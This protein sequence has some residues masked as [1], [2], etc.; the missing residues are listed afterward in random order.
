MFVSEVHAKW[1]NYA[2]QTRSV[3]MDA[4]QHS[5]ADTMRGRLS[6]ALHYSDT[7]NGEKALVAYALENGES[8]T[9]YKLFNYTDERPLLTVKYW[10]VDGNVTSRRVD[11]REVDPSAC[12][13]T[14]L[15]AFTAY[16]A[17]RGGSKSGI[18]SV[19]PGEN[20]EKPCQDD[21]VMLE[22]LDYLSIT[23]EMMMKQYELGSLAGFSRYNSDY[24]LLI[25][26]PAL[27]ITA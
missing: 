15:M 10:D 22:K 5:F 8:A 21:G 4:G 13:Y 26:A 14:E 6:P 2:A 12:D 24:Q 3:G 7:E 23:K 19:V 1:S 9:V 18:P 11:P 16:Q 20:Q 25:E 27:L 17:E